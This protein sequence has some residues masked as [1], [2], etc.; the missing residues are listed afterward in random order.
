MRLLGGEVSTSSRLVA[1]IDALN[2]TIGASVA[3]L[4]L[5]MVLF[6]PLPDGLFVYAL[7]IFAWLLFAFSVSWAVAMSVQ[8]EGWATFGMIASMVLI[9][10][11]IMALSQ[12]PAISDRVRDDAVVW[13]APAVAILSILTMLAVAIIAATTWQHA[14]KPAFY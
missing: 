3:W 14:R 10:P 13:T 2:R 4:T 6:T 5:G 9:N 11:Y 1:G 7:L 8:S 12:I